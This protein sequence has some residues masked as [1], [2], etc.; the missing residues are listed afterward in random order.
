M[1]AI[2]CAK[3]IDIRARAPEARFDNAAR[4]ERVRLMALRDMPRFVSVNTFFSM[5][6]Y[7]MLPPRHAAFFMFY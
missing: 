4:R 6:L 5:P 1:S 2:C 3:E 7:A